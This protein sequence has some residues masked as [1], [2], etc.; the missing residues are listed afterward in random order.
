MKWLTYLP[1]YLP[2]CLPIFLPVSSPIYLPTSLSACPSTTCVPVYLP[3]DHFHQPTNLPT[4]PPA[5]LCTRLYAGTRDCALEIRGVD[6]AADLLAGGVD[7]VYR[8]SGCFDGKPLYMRH[9]S[10]GAGE[11]C[12]KLRHLATWGKGS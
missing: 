9:M 12:S 3:S 11:H 10:D 1:I 5:Y 4:Y 2:T 7:G 8:L 6:L